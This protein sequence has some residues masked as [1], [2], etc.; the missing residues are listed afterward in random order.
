MGAI[1]NRRLKL[2]ELFG[3]QEPHLDSALVID[4]DLNFQPVI[5]L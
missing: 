5:R 4:T 3:P 2:I 1:I